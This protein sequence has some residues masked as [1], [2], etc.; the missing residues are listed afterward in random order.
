MTL[1]YLERFNVDEININFSRIAE[2]LNSVS[3][4]QTAELN[5]LDEAQSI[6][7]I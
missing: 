4:E 2:F 5:L 1:I 6:P 7:G 3:H